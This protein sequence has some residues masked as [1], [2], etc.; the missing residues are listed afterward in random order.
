MAR[1]RF[2]P[3]FDPDGGDALLSTARQDIAVGRWREPARPAEGHRPAWPVRDHRMRLL[4][5]ACV[6]NSS[7]ESW[8]AAEPRGGD[9]LV[10]R[11]ATEVARAFHLAGA[12]GGGAPVERR[13]VDQAVMACLQGAEASPDD[14]TPWICLISVARLYPAGVHRQELGRWWDEVARP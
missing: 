1:D 2:T 6:D 13:R 4:A 7:V 11:A 9:A 14:P 5:A 10:L 3:D 8:L 12:A